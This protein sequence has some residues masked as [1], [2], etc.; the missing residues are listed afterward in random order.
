[1]SRIAY[2]DGRYLPLA[3]AGVNV[4]DRGL[5]FADSVYEV[6]LVER[7]RLVDE[8]PHLDRLDRSLKEIRMAAGVSRPALKCII[9]EVLRLNRIDHGM[10]YIQATRGAAPRNPAFPAIARTTIIMTARQLP[11]ASP[12]RLAEGI[13]VMTIPDI[14]WGRCD[15]KSVALL[16]NVLAKQGALEAGYFDAW[17]VDAD[18]YVT[19][20]SA[21]NAWI[22]TTDKE[23]LTRPATAAILKGVTRATVIALAAQLDIK[24]VERRFS[25]AEA[26]SAAEAFQTNASARIAPVTRIDDSVI[27]NGQAGS[28][29]MALI[30]R[31]RRYTAAGASDG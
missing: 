1:M 25:V 23:L 19:E 3:A 20:G 15:I 17:Q 8:T 7:G 11:P 18:G 2:V 4:E 14:R 5:Q 24:V 27:G 22:V 16:A 13:A 30:D 31:Y 21:S 6:I 28:M 10:L 9:R 26:K 12:Q 29:T